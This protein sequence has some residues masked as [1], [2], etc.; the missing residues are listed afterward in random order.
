MAYVDK[1]VFCLINFP[2]RFLNE[3]NIPPDNISYFNF[4]GIDLTRKI[5]PY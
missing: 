4:S 3:L 2:I 5:F 1:E